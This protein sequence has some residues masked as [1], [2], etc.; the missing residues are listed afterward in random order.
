MGIKLILQK[1]VPSEK[2]EFEQKPIEEKEPNGD[3]TTN[4]HSNGYI[5]LYWYG[6]R[7]YDSYITRFSQPDSIVPFASQGVQA[8]DRY[9]YANNNPVSYTDPTGHCIFGLDTAVCVI[10]ALAVM[11]IILAS[12]TTAHPPPNNYPINANGGPNCKSSLPDC[13][14]DIVTLKDFPGNGEGNPIPVDEF[15]DFADKVSEDLYSHDL[16]WPGY[17]AGRQAYDTPFYNGG[18]SVNRTGDR[19]AESGIYSADQQVCIETLRCS[20]RSEINYIAQG[21]WG[22]AVGEPKFVSHTI[23]WTWKLWEYHNPPSEDT[24][25]WLDYGYDY[26]QQ[27]QKNQQK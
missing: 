17:M 4:Q 21:M 2:I 5:N 23:V 16:T 25:F 12:D 1:K 6:S 9:A 8:L 10:A 27:W 26:Y 19:D 11:T 3:Y 24:L 7:W 20:G 22:A 18:Q 13:F 14:G 15:R